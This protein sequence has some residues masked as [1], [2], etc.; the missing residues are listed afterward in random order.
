M[1]P[2]FEFKYNDKIYLCQH[3]GFD[4]KPELLI[5]HKADYLVHR[6]HTL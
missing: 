2:Y 3:Y 4:E 6:T 1:I 5:D